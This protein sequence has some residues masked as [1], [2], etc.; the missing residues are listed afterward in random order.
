MPG[1]EIKCESLDVRTIEFN[2][3]FISDLTTMENY[4]IS[5]FNFKF[6]LS[7]IALELT[8]ICEGWFIMPSR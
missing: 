5:R 7:I 6:L 4:F 3:K 2:I 1:M 8:Y